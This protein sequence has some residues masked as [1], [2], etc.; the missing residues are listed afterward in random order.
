M[1]S[2]FFL[3]K[4]ELPIKN[5][6][7]YESIMEITEYVL[8]LRLVMDGLRYYCLQYFGC[9]ATFYLVERPDNEEMTVEAIQRQ[10]DVYD[11]LAKDSHSKPKRVVIT[12]VP[13]NTLFSYPYRN[14]ELRIDENDELHV[15]GPSDHVTE[16]SNQMAR[17]IISVMQQPDGSMRM[18]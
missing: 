7:P 6:S 14:I 12:I 16:L 18:A 9:D 10:L 1:S 8:K 15:M 13:G 4:N 11:A 5:F 3:V 2:L 17:V